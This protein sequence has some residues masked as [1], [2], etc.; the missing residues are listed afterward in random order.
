MEE[1]CIECQ[2]LKWFEKENL[3]TKCFIRV[4]EIRFIIKWIEEEINIIEILWKYQIESLTQK[5]ILQ[6]KQ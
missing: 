5:T 3:Q 6:I 4:I 2:R 1:C